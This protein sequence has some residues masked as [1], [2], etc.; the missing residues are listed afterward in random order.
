MFRGDWK[1]YDLGGIDDLCH[2][3]DHLCRLPSDLAVSKDVRGQEEA[4][5]GHR[6]CYAHGG[7]ALCVALKLA[8]ATDVGPI[9]VLAPLWRRFHYDDRPA[10]LADQAR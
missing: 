5:P 6:V 8:S 9:P 4:G 10:N 1:T 2:H 7:S 3:R